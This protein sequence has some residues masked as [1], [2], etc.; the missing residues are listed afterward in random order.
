M[1][2][3]F[4]F[5]KVFLTFQKKFSIL[6]KVVIIYFKVVIIFFYYKTHLYFF[7]VFL[8]LFNSFLFVFFHKLQ[9]FI[10]IN[11]LLSFFVSAKIKNQNF[12]QKILTFSFLFSHVKEMKSE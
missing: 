4:Y 10:M 5:L 9:F 2:S 7:K 3:N 11:H 12:T 8:I 6:L 1:F